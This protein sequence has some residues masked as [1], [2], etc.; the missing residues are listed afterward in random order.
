MLLASLFAYAVSGAFL[1]FAYFGLFYQIVA[2]TVIL[3]F[4]AEREIAAERAAQ[5]QPL[6]AEET[7]LTVAT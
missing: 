5:T 4:L 6:N 7:P 3:K 2:T 1:G